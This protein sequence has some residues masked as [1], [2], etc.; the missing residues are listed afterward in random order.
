MTDMR[1]CMVWLTGHRP[2]RADVKG[3]DYGGL[4]KIGAAIAVAALLCA[5]NMAVFASTSLPAI[6]TPLWLQ[7][8]AG[9]VAGLMI[10][11]VL[12]RGMVY[13]LDTQV[14]GSRWAMFAYVLVRAG[15]IVA[16]GYFTSQAV[17]PV[18]LGPELKGHALS[19]Q[20]QSQAKR[21]KQLHEVLGVDALV[22]ANTTGQQELQ[23]AREALRSLPSGI[24]AQLLDAQACWRRLA[25]WRQ[26]LRKQGF[27]AADVSL[28]TRALNSSCS[29]AH[30][31]AQSVRDAYLDQA[32]KALAKAEKAAEGASHDLADTQRE[33]KQKKKLAAEVEQQ[34][35]THTSAEVLQSLLASSPG[36]RLKWLVLTFLQLSLELLPLVL[37]FQA[38]QS[39]VGRQIGVRR[40]LKLMAQDR[41]LDMAQQRQRLHQTLADVSAIT[42]KGLAQSD[43]LRQTIEQELERLAKGL[44][45]V[46]TVQTVLEEIAQQDGLVREA[47][48]KHPGHAAAMAEAWSSAM[49][50]A[51]RAATA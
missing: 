12:D 33:L 46:Q 9:A 25:T 41:V 2:A 14:G 35:F 50:R 28:R 30:A 43:Q 34:A 40:H 31:Q 48:T 17:M 7:T 44:A 20:E 32:Q 3:E 5:L 11:L 1:A 45:P 15:M 27:D 23:T 22:L 37:K 38:G 6:L 8:A 42:A 51:V 4:S 26:A 10:V 19:M 29:Q 16:L 49:Q 21:A 39:P 36:A 18:L 47:M 13:L 24:Q